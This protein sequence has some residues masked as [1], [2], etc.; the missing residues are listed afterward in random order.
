MSLSVSLVHCGAV[1]HG[2]SF[3][4]AFEEFTEI[5]VLVQLMH[6]W[7]AYTHNASQAIIERKGRICLTRSLGDLAILAELC[8]L[9]II[10]G[11][12]GDPFFLELHMDGWSW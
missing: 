12:G 5:P 3:S 7:C 9:Y 6:A 11:G 2:L 10:Q 8:W 4:T 1:E